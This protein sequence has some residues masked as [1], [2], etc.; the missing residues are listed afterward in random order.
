M[1][2]GFFLA[3]HDFAFA[4][5]PLEHN[6]QAYCIFILTQRSQNGNATVLKVWNTNTGSLVCIKVRLQGEKTTSNGPCSATHPPSK[7]TSSYH[8]HWG[9]LRVPVLGKMVQA[10]AAERDIVVGGP[11][12][13][14][15]Y[16]DTE[17]EMAQEAQK[18]VQGAL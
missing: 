15:R 18:M 8:R 11:H 14:G 12:T 2:L 9:T 16:D 4:C 3:L 13:E 10:L 7:E 5:E 1:I 6:L 17:T